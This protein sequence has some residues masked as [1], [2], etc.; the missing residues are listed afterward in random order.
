MQRERIIDVAA[1]L[2]RR[3]GPEAVT[4]RAVATAAGVQP[5]ALYR[6]FGDKDGLLDAVAEHVFGAY[7]AG[8]P[9]PATDDP[10]AD[11]RAGWD[12]H[13][14]FGLEN[15]GLTALLAQ[16]ARASRSPAIVAG[17]EVLRGRVRRVAEAGRLRVPEERAVLLIHAAGTGTV[18]AL[19]ATPPAERDAGLA[20]AAWDAVAA[21][22]LTDAP[23][24]TADPLR[25]AAITLRGG[26]DDLTSLRPAERALLADWL[27]RELTDR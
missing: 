24:A 21:A 7:V 8:K 27:D 5:P 4:T 1:D 19:L 22:I 14:T 10:V 2:L 9:A 6:Q 15:P 18:S 16:P 3:E 20:G 17:I 26:L 13:V 23:T 11:L 12:L 25:T